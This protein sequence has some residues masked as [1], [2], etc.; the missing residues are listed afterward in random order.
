MYLV[1]LK[2]SLFETKIREKING[3]V[4]PASV[5]SGHWRCTDLQTNR[6]GEIF[7]QFERSNN[8]CDL[9]GEWPKLCAAV[10]PQGDAVVQEF[11]A[12]LETRSWAV[13]DFEKDRS[14]VQSP[15]RSSAYW[16]KYAGM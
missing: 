4:Y 5:S 14:V 11:Q 10:N 7:R 2:R 1:V 6:V 3:S 15:K 9:K 13:V 12:E 8:P 16:W